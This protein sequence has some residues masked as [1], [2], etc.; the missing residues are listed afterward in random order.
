MH[1]FLSLKVSA[2]LVAVSLVQAKVNVL[3]W[4]QAYSRAHS[5]VDQMSL[6]QKVA[7]ATGTGY[8]NGL[9]TG[10]SYSI[11]NPNFPSLCLQDSSMG[12][13]LA[14]DV[15][16]GVAGINAAAS[17]DKAAIRARGEY[18]GK[19]FR[20]K[21]INV[22]LGPSLDF[23]RSPYGGRMWESGGEDPYLM[24]VLASETVEGIQDQGVIAMAKH[25]ILDDQ[26]L[27]RNSPSLQIDERTLHEVY[28][29]PFARAVE[30]GVGAVMCAY[31]KIDGSYSCENDYLLNTVLKNEL[32]FKGFVC[33]DWLATMSTIKAV[34]SGLDMEM[35]GDT[36]F[37]GGYFGRNLTDAVR[38]RLVS[39]ERTTDMAMRIVAAW[40]KMRQDQSYPPVAVDALFPYSAPLV[41]VK[42]DH[43]KLVREMGAASNILLKNTNNILP[44][45][46]NNVRRIAIIGSDAG[47]YPEGRHCEDREC[48]GG[49]LGS[50]PGTVKFPYYVDP[51]QGLSG[52]FGYRTQV[53]SSLDDWDL[54]KAARTANG[55]DYAIVFVSANSG[56]ENDINGDAGDRRNL[57]LWQNG[58]NLVRTVADANRN[59]IVVVHSVG[60]V[61]MPWIDHPNIKAVLWPGLPGQES[62]NSLADVITG[63]VNP[64]GR[65]PY[66]IAKREGDYVTSNI[67][68]S[69]VNYNERL[70]VGYKWFDYAGIEP[71]FPFGHGLSY[72]KFS[73]NRWKYSAN[74]STHYKSDDG[75]RGEDK[76]VQ[77]ADVL[78]DT[79]ILN[80]GP[81]DGA[82]IVQLYITFPGGY[83]EPPKSLRGFEKVFL[84]RGE[85]Y[86]VHFRLQRKE[87]SIWDTF[88]KDWVIPS[89]EYTI[90]IGA[91]S[92]DIRQSGKFSL[93]V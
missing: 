75:W 42:Q 49:A 22:Q 26:E 39:E 3:S 37:G 93:F 7:I 48:T 40:F 25:F 57:Y 10:N 50:G 76:L 81:Y 87:L 47:P 66:T 82:E 8:M 59:T 15:T 34:N 33:S 46:P 31:N 60:P 79:S 12:V 29:W 65:L 2:L 69:P 20:G 23:A 86:N 11:R 58:D 45:D 55:A 27:Y 70:L 92:R 89:G 78:I 28:L 36:T 56:N 68:G 18:M 9:C 77:E 61:N 54:N 14:D 38:R 32:D 64:S 74:F 71:L 19:E 53:H 51:L 6:A 73:Y 44:L 17:F 35:P 62:G 85:A 5:I 84:R 83:G 80:A 4:D 67:R 72:T 88:A 24:G 21:G 1:S 16:A 41:D 30:S 43:Y 52:A 90:H 91:S 13:H 63:K